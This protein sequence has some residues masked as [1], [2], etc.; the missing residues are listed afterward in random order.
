MNTKIGTS[1]GLAMLMVIGVIA[2]MF[3]LGTFTAKPAS[4]AI[5]TVTMVSTPTTA[6]ATAQHTVTVSGNGTQAAIAV[7][8]TIT[9]TFDSKFTVP[10]AIAASSI[11]IK[12]DAV[13]NTGTANELVS[14]GAVT[15]SGRAVTLT[16]PDMS[17]P[18]VSDGDNGIAA[19]AVVTITF[20]QSAVIVNPK[21][22]VAAS[23]RSVTVKSTGDTAAVTSGTSSAVTHSVTYTPTT[24]ARGATVTVTGKGFTANCDDCKIR[25]N[26]Q[27]NVLSVPTTGNEGSG[28]I[29]A[30]GVFTGTIV[31]DASSNRASNYIW[32][33]D[34]TGTGAAASTVWV[35]K[36]GATPTSTSVTPGSTVTSTLVDFTAS[37]VMGVSAVTV[38]SDSSV[39]NTANTLNSS[40]NTAALTPF[41]FVMPIG[42]TTGSHKVTISDS[43]SPVKSATFNIDVIAR[44]LTVVPNPAAIGQ[45]ITI[46]GT[47]FKKSGTISS[48]S[49]SGGADLQAGTTITIDSAGAWSHSTTMDTL[50]A[51]A[52]RTSDAYTIT[53]TDNTLL[54]GASSGFKRTARTLTIN[55]TQAAP[56]VA[57]TVSVTGMT[58][59]NGEV[60]AENASFTISA[61]QSSANLALA[62][63]VNFPVSS[64]GSGTGTITVPLAATVATITF[65]A[66]DN[67][68]L[69]NPVGALGKGL[70]TANQTA[71]ANL[72]VKAGIISVEPASASTGKVVTVTGSNFPPNT[73]GTVLTFGTSSGI[74]AGGFKSDGIGAFSF[75]TEIPAAS[76]GG[77]LTPG[78]K[79]VTA[80]VGAI[81][82]TTTNFLIASPSITITP[83]EAAPQDMIVITGTGF[84]ALSAISTLTIGSA[85]ANPSPAPRAGRSG[86]IEATVEVPLLNPGTYTVVV[87]NN[88]GFTATGTFKAVAAKA[89]VSASTDNTETVFADVISNSDNLVRV[90]RFNNADQGWSFFDPRAAF[91][92]ANTLAKTGA[93]DIVWVSV[94]AEQ[95]FQ[96]GTLFQGW[97]LIVLN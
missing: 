28:S 82:G 96:G 22:A 73:T 70:A 80:T 58:V 25:M 56:G 92:D 46:S 7:G 52:G 67:A 43:G 84:N 95:T 88:T 62:G 51:S 47:G 77:S 36:A 74:P 14:V 87:T 54:V 30:N 29:D 79:I 3:A 6:G 8:E 24:A 40:G 91:S 90:W 11:K 50:G 34:A 2:T 21:L 12:A 41:K 81:T 76:N 18:S 39:V 55:E 57:V 60:A 68:L 94:L 64:D 93:G 5:G 78:N 42:T 86:D 26:P 65:T 71:T 9:V 38:G 17:Q 44:T 89:P 72:S 33:V 45:A 20:L 10:S 97:S 31:T 13:T 83:A 75:T 16:V 4:A 19:N 63:T 49:G 66:T 35:Q 85:P 23:I 15:V 37:A 69:L 53:A 59:D 61:V 48:I 1:F 32:V 27:N